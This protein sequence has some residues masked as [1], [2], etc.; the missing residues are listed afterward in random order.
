MDTE[1]NETTPFTNGFIGSSVLGINLE[2][3]GH[4]PLKIKFVKK[5]SKTM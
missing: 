4:F 1:W 3:Q 5:N 2:K